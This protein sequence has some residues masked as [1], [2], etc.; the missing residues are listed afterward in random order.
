MRT[1]P[2]GNLVILA[3]LTIARAL[4]LP[5]AAVAAGLAS[6]AWHKL[7]LVPDTVR[8]VATRTCAQQAR[9]EAGIDLDA[10][11]THYGSGLLVIDAR[12]AAEFEKGHLAALDILNVPPQDVHSQMA[13]LS[14]REGEPIVL[15]CTSLKCDLSEELYCDMQRMGF[16]NLKIYFPGWD[17]GIVKEG[18]PVASGPGPDP[19][20]DQEPTRAVPQPDGEKPNGD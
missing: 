13:V 9:A 14:G 18:L 12:P 7:P 6:A 4:I 20:S 17:D 5:V 16:M 8:I 11:R 2:S 3:M 19:E 15:Y 10:F 1:E